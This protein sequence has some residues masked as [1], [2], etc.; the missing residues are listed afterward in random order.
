MRCYSKAGFLRRVSEARFHV[1]SLGVEHFGA[2][3]FARGGI[4]ER[5]VLYVVEK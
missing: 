1:R 5:S 2:A 4:T 3:V